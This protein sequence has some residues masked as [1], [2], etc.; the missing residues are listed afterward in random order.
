MRALVTGGAGFI[1]AVL[2]RQLREG[3]VPVT[4]IDRLPRAAARRLRDLEG[5]DGLTYIEA[6]LDDADLLAAVLA[7]HRTVF[8]LAANTENRADRAGA[9][10]DVEGTVAGTAALLRALAPDAGTTVVLT[11]S[12]LVYAPAA[13]PISERTGRLAPA[14]PFAAGKVAAE[15]FLAAH[16]REGGHRGVV[17]RLSNIVGPGMGR[18]VIHDMVSGLRDEPDRIRVLGDG[19]Q[20]RSFLHVE[21]C[22]AGLIAA[23]TGGTDDLAVYNVCNL[24]A[25]SAATVAEIVAE[26]VDGPPPEIEFAGGEN[27]WRGDV[28]T[29]R[30]RPEALLETGWRPAADSRAAV[31]AT[32]RAML[33]ARGSEVERWQVLAR[34][35]LYDSEWAGLSLVTVKPPGQEPYDHHVVALPAAVGVVVSCAEKGVLLLRRH[36]FITDSVGYEVPAGG[37]EK[38]ESIEAAA[39]REVLEETGWRLAEAERLVSCNVSDGV[40]DQRFHFVL[41]R[42][43][44]YVGPPVDGHEADSLDWVE[45]GRV[46]DLIGAG[47]VPGALSLVALLYAMSFDRI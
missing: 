9:D 45:P 36:R 27:G 35:P 3:G 7:G 40:S 47:E 16:C 38:T 29:L 24:D 17:C 4:V 19:R 42:P 44:E 21:D 33:A 12:Q 6:G 5:D 46:R 10:A 28:P 34:K 32:V 39:A 15:A 23:T 13:D 22:A 37:L 11:S 18:G 8:H 1:G 41:G 30:V 43:E 20:T 14:T 26:E 2:V 25:L 31:R